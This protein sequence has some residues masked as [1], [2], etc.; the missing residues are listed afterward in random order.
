METRAP[1]TEA[2][3]ADSRT[4]RVRAGGETA[5]YPVRLGRG[6]RAEVAELL[7]ELAPAHRYAVISDAT[8]A[9]LHGRELTDALVEAGLDARLFTFPA[10]EEN[11]TREEWTRLTDALLDAGVGRDGGLVAVGGGVTGDLAGFVAATY[12]R[13]IPVIQV[14]TSL[15]AMIDASVGGK[16]G[17][18]V[19]AGKNL[20]GAF[21]PP[22]LVLADPEVV[23]T[24]PRGERS[25]GL[26][27]AVKHGAI[28]DREYLEALERDADALLDADPDA[29]LEAVHR[30]VEIK[31]DVVSRDEREGGLRKV[32]NFGHTVGHALEAAAG[33]G[34]PHGSAIAAG[35]VLEVRIGEMLEVTEPGTAAELT[36]ILERFELPTSPPAGLDPD[37]VFGYTRA[38]KKGRAGRPRYVLLRRPG[39]VARGEGW[40]HPVPDDLL[41]E[42]LDEVFGT[43]ETNGGSRG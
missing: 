28:R 26:A 22:R 11:K 30:S 15:V 39:E 13:G 7:R 24:L 5:D 35:M 25:Q 2:A 12:M 16:T 1:P 10:G 19:A 31:A 34:L 32:L 43:T 29:L 20:V 21:H 41:R 14:P 33:Y 23:S 8:V 38:D 17:V 42:L 4:V 36:R 37:A 6:V 27:E 40:S 18:D 9:E 3:V